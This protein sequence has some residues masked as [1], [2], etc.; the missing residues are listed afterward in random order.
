[1]QAV[2]WVRERV[3]L[4]LVGLLG[5]AA[6]LCRVWALDRLPGVGDEV[7]LSVRAIDFLAGKSIE[8]FSPTGNPLNPFLALPMVA[9]EAIHGSAS[10]LNLRIPTLIA[11]LLAMVLAYPLTRK[12][13]GRQRALIFAVLVWV[14]PVHIAYDR[15]GWDPSETPLMALLCLA[16]LLHR[17]MDWMVLAL[18]AAV[19]VHPTNV[20]LTPILAGGVTGQILW[21]RRRLAMGD[22]AW[23]SSG[24]LVIGAFFAW[25]I[26]G[27]ASYPQGSPEFNVDFFVGVVLGI[28]RFLSGVTTLHYIVGPMSRLTRIL[29]ESVFW[30]SV[31]LL[32]VTGLPARVRARDGALVGMILGMLVAIVGVAASGGLLFLLPGFERYSLFLT[33]PSCFIFASLLVRPTGDGAQAGAFASPCLP[34]VVALVA[35]FLWLGVFIA[36]YHVKLETIGSRSHA[37]FNSAAQEPKVAAFALIES[38]APA[39]PVLIITENYW[40]YWPMR[41]FGARDARVE[42]EEFDAESPR[43]LAGPDYASHAVFAVGFSKDALSRSI[44]RGRRARD[45]GRPVWKRT[46]DDPQGLPILDVWRLR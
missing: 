44:E 24:L 40:T 30:S 26:S 22:W 9:V 5:V 33:V 2:S 28:G 21:E 35:C 6:V 32:L 15:M 14:V 37:I 46:F 18:L 42:V 41:Y 12:V 3:L 34:V 25:R 13:V 45:W 29:V 23:V 31:L 17:R 38:E 1:M 39:G 16:A 7:W 11:G 4:I 20:F 19:W 27:T 43:D 10:V 8:W 36:Q